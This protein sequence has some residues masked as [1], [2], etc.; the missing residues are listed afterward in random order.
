MFHLE[1][2]DM[3]R[4]ADFLKKVRELAENNNMSATAKALK[5]PVYTLRARL[6]NS[7]MKLG[8]IPP[9]FARTRVTKK[10]SKAIKR[11]HFDT[12]RTAGK[13]GVSKRVII[14]QQIFQELDWNKG[15]NVVI[16]RSGKNK[17]IIEKTAN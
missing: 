11:K 9:Q 1:K 3:K 2:V 4:D 14:P 5:M 8:E 17:I 12:V 7:T 16:R 15:D 10:A 13:A 6:L